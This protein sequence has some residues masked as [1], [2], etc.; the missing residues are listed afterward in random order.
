MA[1][2]RDQPG[3]ARSIGTAITA[4]VNAVLDH[5]RV[6]FDASATVLAA[7]PAE[8]AGLVL[9]AVV[10]QLLEGGH[11]D[12]LDEDD[13]R[14]VLSRCFQD[15][16]GWLPAA[17]IDVA[18]LV[19]VLSGALG[20]QEPGVTYREILGTDAP[21]SGGRGDTDVWVDPDLAG[22]AVGRGRPAGPE[23]SAVVRDTVPTTVQYCRH[24]PLLI[25]DLLPAGRRSLA[26]HLD[27]A[28][29]ELA[30][31]QTMEMP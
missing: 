20:I 11:V 28:F 31:A 26:V 7:L 29:T 14:L 23:S 13:I 21:G 19:A 27:R 15:A 24:A 22:G 5:D 16:T 25:A 2:W 4:A 8:Q 1:S 6:A 12:G 3:P 18:T 30:G 10:R 9:A 17:E